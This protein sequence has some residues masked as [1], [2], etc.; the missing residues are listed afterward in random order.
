MTN[1]NRTFKEVLRKWGHDILY[2]RKLDD[3][4]YSS[5]FERIT[6]RHMYPANSVLVNLTKEVSEGTIVDSAEMLY[7]FDCSV[8]PRQGDRI[9]ENIKSHPQPDSVYRVDYAIPMRGKFGKIEYW[10]AGATREKPV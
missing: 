2:Q 5:K 7:Y 8:N 10:V 6:T 3:R 1:L 9:Y 4:N